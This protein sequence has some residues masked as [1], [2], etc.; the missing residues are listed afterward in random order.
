MISSQD[1]KGWAA[2]ICAGPLSIGLVLLLVGCGN[3]FRP[4]A[5]PIQQSGGDPGTLRNAIIVSS[6]PAGVG[7]TEHIDV[8]GDTISSI[9]NVGAAPVQAIL[10]GGRTWVANK[11]DGTLTGYTTFGGPGVSTVTATLPAGACPLLMSSQE[12][13]SLYVADPGGSCV[14]SG[15]GTVDVV[16]LSTAAFSGAVAVGVNPVSLAELPNASKIYVANQGSNSLTVIT[17]SDHSVEVFP[18]NQNF[19]TVGTS[20]SF[21]LASSD[22]ACVYVANQGSDSISVI[23]TSSDAVSSTLTLPSGS[24][25]SFLTFDPNLQRVYV[26]N[27]AGNSMLN[28][29]NTCVL[30]P[31]DVKTVPLLGG[32]AP[33]SIASLADGTRL[34]VADSGSGSVSVINASSLTIKTFANASNGILVGTNPVSVAA[35]PDSKRV[36]VANHDSGN[37]SIIQTGNDTEL[38]RLPA[39]SPNPSFVLVTP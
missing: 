35:S 26:A 32:L 24:G 16:G 2:K 15:N 30:Q 13:T 1:L 39:S 38:S 37:I 5:I 19:I 12:N 28:H 3:T 34:Y 25:P 29:H 21:V 18:N 20:P 27:T 6:N 33:K 4:I 23:S 10:A 9:H 22:S 14:P 7:T 11:G 36:Y 17:A 8:A 31:S